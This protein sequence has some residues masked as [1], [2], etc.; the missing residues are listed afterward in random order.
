VED[1]TNEWLKEVVKARGFAWDLD[2][3]DKQRKQEARIGRQNRRHG[4]L[5][6]S[7]SKQNNTRSSLGPKQTGLAN[8]PHSRAVSSTGIEFS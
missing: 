5:P 2:W 3:F 8:V 1:D 6:W 7:I 4:R